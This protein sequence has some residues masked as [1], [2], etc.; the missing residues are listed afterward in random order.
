M[1]KNEY[2]EWLLDTVGGHTANGI[3]Y[4]KLFKK[5]FSTPFRWTVENDSN[6]ATDGLELRDKFFEETDAD[7]IQV[8]F[9]ECSVLE[10]MVALSIRCETDIMA[11]PLDDMVPS[12]WFWEMIDNLGLASMTDDY[13]DERYVEGR[14]NRW[15]NREYDRDGFGGLFPL[16]RADKDQRKVEIWFQLCAYLDQNYEVR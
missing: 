6:R 13:F 8:V 16:K 11:D 9:D 15:E 3:R 10:M 2:Y 5:L 4:M 1:R 12:R 14:L 7:S